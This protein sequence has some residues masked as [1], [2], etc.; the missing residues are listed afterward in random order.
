MPK[1][2]IMNVLKAQISQ[3]ITHILL[4]KNHSKIKQK[5]IFILNLVLPFA[6]I[7]AKKALN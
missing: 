1:L 4:I 3:L 2:L 5:Q 7:I 6:C